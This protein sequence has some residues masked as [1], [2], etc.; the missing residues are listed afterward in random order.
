MVPILFIPQYTDLGSCYLHFCIKEHKVRVNLS[1][2]LSFF[3]IRRILAWFQNFRV[4]N[5]YVIW[6]WNKKYSCIISNLV[7]LKLIILLYYHKIRMLIF[8]YQR[9]SEL[10]CLVVFKNLDSVCKTQHYS[11]R[12]LYKCNCWKVSTPHLIPNICKAFLYML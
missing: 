9:P 1:E 6:P 5:N 2:V 8:I 3:L 11:K 7:N 4:S 10:H 12:K